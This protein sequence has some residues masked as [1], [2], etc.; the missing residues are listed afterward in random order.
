[1][2]NACIPVHKTNHPPELVGFIP[3]DFLSEDSKVTIIPVVYHHLVVHVTDS[4]SHI[5]KAPLFITAEQ[6]KNISSELE[7]KTYNYFAMT[8][9]VHGVEERLNYLIIISPIKEKLILKND[10]IKGWSQES[11]GF[12][13]GEELDRLIQAITLDKTIDYQ[14]IFKVESLVETVELNWNKQ[15]RQKVVEF[16]KQ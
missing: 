5:L 2:L 15:T 3:D 1:M 12:F 10:N 11:R 7:T 13:N 9:T 6:I 8:G 16:L 14:K 4:D